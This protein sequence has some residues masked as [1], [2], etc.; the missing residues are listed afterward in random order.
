M[1][2]FRTRLT[3]AVGYDITDITDGEWLEYTVDLE[4][5][6]Y[7]IVA[8]ASYDGADTP[9]NRLSLGDGP[10]G[11]NL[12]DLGTI[13]ITST[14]SATTWNEF[15]L[16]NVLIDAD[17]QG[18]VLR[19]EM[20]GG[21]FDLNWLQ[22]QHRDPQDYQLVIDLLPPSTATGPTY[23]ID[24][25]GQSGPTADNWVGLD[26]AGADSNAN[27]ARTTVSGATFEV[28][29]ANA[30]RDRGKPNALIQDEI[31]AEGST[32][33]VGLRVF[34]LPAGVY[35][36]EVWVWDQNVS[37]G[38]VKIGTTE[39]NGKD[40]FYTTSFEA[41]AKT[42][43]V[44]QF[45]S[46]ELDEGFGIIVEQ[47]NGGKHARLNALRLTP[48][49]SSALNSDDQAVQ[50]FF[51]GGVPLQVNTGNGPTVNVTGT[52]G[53]EYSGQASVA[54][55]NSKPKVGVNVG[56]GAQVSGTDV[57]ITSFSGTRV[58]SIAS[59][60]SIGVLAIGDATANLTIEN[61]S[62]IDIGAGAA[63]T[64]TTGDLEL[65]ATS[66]ET[67]TAKTTS[68]GGG[69]VKVSVA[70]TTSNISHSTTVDIGDSAALN[71]PQGSLQIAAL[72]NKEG[73]SD[74]RRQRGRRICRRKCNR[75]TDGSKLNGD[76]NDWQERHA[77]R[78]L[79]HPRCQD[80]NWLLRR[81]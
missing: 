46:S 13:D 70:H 34:G 80:W 14:G 9:S 66:T 35:T 40:K 62:G 2:I 75:H 64:A 50:Q 21:G 32:A 22:F 57:E 10:D 69:A 45:D 6:L 77:R 41:T 38:K 39:F 17:A 30:S 25:N 74:R 53:A 56:A 55:A 31:H 29:G 59:G 3:K 15:V 20:S 78:G 33:A 42:P 79:N 60:L 43:F 73:I 24:V 26:V 36:A 23:S 52:A 81:T 44:F 61:T 1:S 48:V 47:N 28:I 19:V 16:S 63:V 8:R 76:N 58:N 65:K 4:S 27:G 7:D 71:A 68:S 5:G 37:V 49:S 72:D 51:V 54:T 18:K 11:R 67:G 12:A